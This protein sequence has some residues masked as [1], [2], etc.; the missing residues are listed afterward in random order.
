[1]GV[2]VAF[3]VN[4]VGSMQQIDRRR[5]KVSRKAQSGFRFSLTTLQ[6]QASDSPSSS[7]VKQ[8]SP[9]CY[10]HT[11]T[12][13][14]VQSSLWTDWEFSVFNLRKH[15]GVGSSEDLGSAHGLPLAMFA[16]KFHTK[17]FLKKTASVTCQALHMQLQNDMFDMSEQH[18]TQLQHDCT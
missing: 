5:H 11:H 8:S 15:R 17:R 2:A 9:S 7:C 12:H 4:L 16:E 1:M 10:L 14:L 3:F 18:C 13:T 6:G